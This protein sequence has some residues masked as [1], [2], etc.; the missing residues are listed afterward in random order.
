[1]KSYDYPFLATPVSRC[2]SRSMRRS[3]IFLVSVARKEDII[4]GWRGGAVN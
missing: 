1:M 3:I 2:N 4:V